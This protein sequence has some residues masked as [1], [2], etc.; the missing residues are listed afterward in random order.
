MKKTRRWIASIS[1]ASSQFQTKSKPQKQTISIL[2]VAMPVLVGL[3]ASGGFAFLSISSDNASQKPLT[4][5]SINFTNLSTKRPNLLTPARVSLSS[6]SATQTDGGVDQSS[7]TD[8]F[9]QSRVCVFSS[10]MLPPNSSNLIGYSVFIRNRWQLRYHCVKF[11][12][13]WSVYSHHNL[14]TSFLSIPLLCKEVEVCWLESGK[15]IPL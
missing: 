5:T 4:P 3:S 6:A 9:K 15:G 13:S 1:T 8:D 10:I 14:Y 11:S 7:L 2:P 12:S